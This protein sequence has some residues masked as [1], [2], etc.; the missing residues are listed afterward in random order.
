MKQQ[1]EDIEKSFPR[2]GSPKSIVSKDSKSTSIVSKNS[3]SSDSLTYVGVVKNVWLRYVIV[4]STLCLIL[5]LSL[6][7]IM[8]I[9]RK[10]LITFM[11]KDVSFP[12]QTN[13]VTLL[14]VILLKICN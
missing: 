13:E 7:I 4:L 10:D 6:S 8:E 12:F 5:C 11:F 9:I 2:P 1:L 14:I 3:K